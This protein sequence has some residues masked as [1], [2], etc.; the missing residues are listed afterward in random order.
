MHTIFAAFLGL[1]LLQAPPRYGYRVVNSYPHDRTAFTQGLEYR[2]GFFWEG[3]GLVGRSTV[4][5]VK[6]ETGQVVQS[7]DVPPPFFGEGITVLPQQLLELTWQ[8]QT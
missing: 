7:F 2:E 8:A 1:F 5:K 6:L 3:T 4:R